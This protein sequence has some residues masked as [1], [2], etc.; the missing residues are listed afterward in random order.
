MLRKLRADPVN[1]LTFEHEDKV[2]VLQEPTSELAR[3]MIRGVEPPPGGL[4]RHDRIHR[5]PDDRRNASGT[6]RVS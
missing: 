2:G 6:N 3:T 4:V 1:V 5:S